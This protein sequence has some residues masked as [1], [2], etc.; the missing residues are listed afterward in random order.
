[1]QVTSSAPIITAT[2]AVTLSLVAH[3]VGSG[4]FHP[5]SGARAA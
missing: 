1:V 5:T 3:G 2:S 4:R